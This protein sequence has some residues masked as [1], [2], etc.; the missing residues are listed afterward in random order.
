[1]MFTRRHSGSVKL[2]TMSVTDA[3][4][5]PTNTRR[6]ANVV[7]ML[8]QRRRLWADIK[9]S[10]V[11]VRVCWGIAVR[12]SFGFVRWYSQVYFSHQVR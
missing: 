3:S 11:S 8:G 6:L 4:P 10:L 1:M 7:F 9:T 12:I 5:I 2:S